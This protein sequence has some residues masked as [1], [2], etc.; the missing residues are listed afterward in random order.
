MKKGFLVTV[1]V[2]VF[3]VGL[4]AF[5][6]G[7][8]A[9]EKVITLRY[10]SFFPAPHANSGAIEGWCKEIEKRTNGKVKITPYHG[11]T[12]TPANQTFDSVIKGVADIG[13][14]DLSYTRGRFP[15]SEVIYLP[16]GYKS[17]YAATKMTNEYVKKFQ[18]KEFD[19]VKILYF[20]N[21]GPGL[22]HT[23]KPVAKLEDMKGMKI[24]STGFSSKIVVALGAAPV[25]M[26]MT[27]AYDALS[28]GVADGIVC[29]YEALKGWKLGEVVADTTEDYACAYTSAFFVAMNKG[30]WASLPP[31]VQKVIEQ[32]SAEWIEKQ[33]KIWDDID[34]EGKEFVQ[35]RG[36]KIVVLSKEEEARWSEKMKPLFDEYLKMTKEKNL[37]GAEALKFCQD[38]LKANQKSSKVVYPHPL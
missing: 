23:K 7:S 20:Y 18:P 1:C 3:V 37:P 14:A 34:K 12:L 4:L 2:A 26:P 27:E 35:K 21:H 19:E 8:Y 16:L 28:K 5:V 33:G 6:P 24:R 13:T 9:Q 38:Y 31:D 36:N 11:A 22:L 29:P 32:V 10:S 30:T 25:G 17:A 15:L